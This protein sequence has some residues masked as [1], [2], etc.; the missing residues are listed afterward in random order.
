MGLESQ[1]LGCPKIVPM[2]S[3][4]TL[5]FGTHWD[6]NLWDWQSRPMLI[7]FLNLAPGPRSSG[8]PLGVKE[9]KSLSL[10]PPT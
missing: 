10:A 9:S 3:P 7:A 2:D 6:E 1:K 8:R 4:R 5:T